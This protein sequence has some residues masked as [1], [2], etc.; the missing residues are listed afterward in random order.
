M[1]TLQDGDFFIDE[2]RPP[3]GVRLLLAG[4]GSKVVLRYQPQ[5][6]NA[7]TPQPQPP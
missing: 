4:G 1:S 3:T 2:A 6:H 7:T 5:R